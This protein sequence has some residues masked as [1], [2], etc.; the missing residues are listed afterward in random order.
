VSA[1]HLPCQVK[2]TVD[3]WP[4][5]AAVDGAMGVADHLPDALRERGAREPAA[6]V[7]YNSGNG[8]GAS[9]GCD[10]GELSFETAVLQALS[11]EGRPQ[12]YRPLSILL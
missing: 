11:D 12:I 9:P 10:S 5:F 2:T 4:G 8:D 3:P 7:A 6:I 1:T